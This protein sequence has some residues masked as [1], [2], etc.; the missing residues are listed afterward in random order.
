VKR[1]AI[2]YYFLSL[3]ERACTICCSM[4]SISKIL[5][6]NCHIVIHFKGYINHNYVLFM[7][8]I[9][10]NQNILW[11]FMSFLYICIKM[12]ISS[13]SQTKPGTLIVKSTAQKFSATINSDVMLKLT[14]LHIHLISG[15]FIFESRIYFQKQGCV[16][17]SGIFKVRYFLDWYDN[18]KLRFKYIFEL[19][20][21]LGVRRPSF[22]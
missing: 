21:S 2:K 8:K 7:C 3:Q 17:F 18:S 9:V 11:L 16:K 12:S 4:V 20:P 6:L 22:V 10:F 14:S 13:L 15:S 19:L 5:T 1:F